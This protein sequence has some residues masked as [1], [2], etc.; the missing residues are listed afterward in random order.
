MV[1]G[2]WGR[3]E[4]CARARGRPFKP[5]GVRRGRPLGAVVAPPQR[6][7]RG[8]A[9][10]RALAER[11]VDAEAFGQADER[12]CGGRSR[13]VRRGRGSVRG[14]PRRADGRLGQPIAGGVERRA[15][16]RGE[17]EAADLR[18]PHLPAEGGTSRSRAHGRH[19]SLGRHGRG[20]TRRCRRRQRGCGRP[21]CVSDRRSSS[22]SCV[23]LVPPSRHQKNS[24]AV[25]CAD[26][27]TRKLR[28]R[29]AHLGG[30]AA[31]L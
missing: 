25:R 12:L 9:V 24:E 28:R 13:R 27:R 4:A 3:P 18:R 20:L 2:S 23:G 29:R 21:V 11:T 7:A 31:E 19:R 16:P 22:A 1:G 15:N 14:V 8:V 30:G 5:A 26:S 10:A 6:L 17:V